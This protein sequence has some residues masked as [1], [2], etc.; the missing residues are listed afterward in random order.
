MKTVPIKPTITIEELGKLDIRA[1][2][3]RAVDDVPGERP[4]PD[5]ARAG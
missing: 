4:V 2:T 1:A 3:I 5:G